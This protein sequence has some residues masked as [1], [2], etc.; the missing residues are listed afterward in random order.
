MLATSKAVCGNAA[1]ARQDIATT[2]YKAG[3]MATII[4]QK[5]VILAGYDQKEREMI[6]VSVMYP[7]NEGATFNMDY[8][9]NSHMPMAQRLLGA[10]AFSIDQGIGGAMPGSAAP[11]IAIGHLLF[12]S[13]GDFQKTI[14]AHGAELM[15]DIVNYTN[16]SPIIQIS[17]V[18]V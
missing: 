5:R 18:K 8:Y 15:A 9:C 13:L 4:C 11:Y 2:V 10:T 3:R 17:E 6:R 14:V 1:P 12:E 7:N 16:S